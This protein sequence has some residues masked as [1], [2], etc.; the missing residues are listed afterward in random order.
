MG[1]CA[2]LRGCRCGGVCGRCLPV[3]AARL[4]ARRAAPRARPWLRAAYGVP[5]C[6]GYVRRPARGRLG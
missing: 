4:L 2:A 5:G 6:A 3:I 1:S